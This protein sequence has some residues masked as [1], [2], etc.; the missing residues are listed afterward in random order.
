MP[1]VT[2]GFFAGPLSQVTRTNLVT[3][4][5]L[6]TNNTG[7]SAPQSGSVTRSTTFSL[8]G[9]ASGRVTAS[10]TVDSNMFTFGTTFSATGTHIGSAYIYIPVGSTLAGRTITIS[11]EGG[12]ASTTNGASIPATL[13]AGSWVRASRVVTVNATGSKSIVFRLSGTLS[14]A[15]GQTLYIDAALLETGSTLLP[16]FDGTYADPYPDHTLLSQQW[17]GTT[18]NSTSTTVWENQISGILD[19]NTS[20]TVTRGRQQVQDPFKAGT[21]TITGLNISTVSGLNIG[22]TLTIKVVAI[23]GSPVSTT[24][25]NGLIANITADYGFTPEEDRWTIEADDALAAAGRAY[26]SNS[27]GAGVTTAIAATLSSSG[28]FVGVVEPYPTTAASR[29]SAQTFNNNNLLDII[30][31]LIATEQGRLVASDPLTILFYNRNTQNLF[32]TLC[33]F[34]DGSVASALPALK[35]QQIV[36]R[37]RAESFFTRTIVEPEGLAAQT[38]GTGQRTFTMQ[39][40]D[41]TTSQASDLAGY[42]LATLDV[43]QDAPSTISYIAENQDSSVVLIGLNAATE[44]LGAQR[45]L[46]VTLRGAQYACFVEGSTISADPAQTRFTLNL[47]SSE[48]SVGLVLDDPILGVL[49]SSKLGF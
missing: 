19:K 31:Q 47:S 5:S 4:P 34:T 20:F 35:Y 2:Y 42:V 29:V 27:F 45:S 46:L 1:A 33:N 38:A 8:V 13:V 18:N 22:D 16:Y 44:T 7:W 40:Y 37:S 43:S 9:G 28:T 6:E 30:N 25:F 32:G 39:S 49:D 36:F 48:A 14:T 15:V 3:N 23:N 24:I 17:N 41:Q 11:Y 12:T 10:S 21:A 26:T